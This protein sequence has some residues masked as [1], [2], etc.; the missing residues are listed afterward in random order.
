M[1][2]KLQPFLLQC[3]CSLTTAHVGHVSQCDT[4]LN[5][6]PF[7]HISSAGSAYFDH[8]SKETST[9]LQLRG[10]GSGQAE[11]SALARSAEFLNPELCVL[12]TRAD[13]TVTTHGMLSDT[14]FSALIAASLSTSSS[15]HN[16]RTS[17]LKRSRALPMLI[18]WKLMS[19][20]FA[21]FR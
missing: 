15:Q 13:H 2:C 21:I 14:A 5:C 6:V 1:V 19:L 9:T 20:I 18:Q 4:H 17:S 16:R 10:R 11:R 3:V 12:A 7:S 8:I